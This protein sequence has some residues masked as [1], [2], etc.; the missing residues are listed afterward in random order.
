MQRS[1]HT[2]KQRTLTGLATINESAFL[3]IVILRACPHF[4]NGDK[5]EI[6]CSQTRKI[7]QIISGY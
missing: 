2:N 6:N 5:N 4:K 1:K 7:A 3:N